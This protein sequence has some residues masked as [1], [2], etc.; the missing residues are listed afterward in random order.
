MILSP[1]DICRNKLSRKSRAK[2]MARAQAKKK[3]QKQKPASKKSQ[4][5][6]EAP[7]TARRGGLPISTAA[8]LDQLAQVNPNAAGIDLGATVHFVAVP[9]GR[10][11]EAHVRCFETFTADLQALADWLEQCG[12][13]TVAMESTGIY[14]I[15]L[16]DLLE[17]R[18]FEVLLINPSDF[19][20]FRRK[21]DVSDCQW[22]QTLHTFGLLQ[23]SFRPHEKI[24]TLRSY[25]RH[26]DNLV[27]CATDEVR[28]MQKALE[29]MNVKLTEVLSDIMGVTGLAIIRAILAGER[30]PQR[31]AQLRD[32]RCKNDVATIALA[33]EGNWREEHLFALRQGL[34]LYE[35]YLQKLA[36]LDEQIEACL[37][38]FEDRSDG[39][40]LS[41]LPRNRALEPELN[42]R[43]LM[44]KL[45]GVDL[46][47]VDGIG[48]QGALQIISEI[49]L[50][51]S[52][53]QTDKH[54]VS[55]LCLCP[56]LRLT[57]GSRKS[58]R[59]RTQPSKNRAAAVFRMGAQSLLRVDCALGAFGR[60]IRA[61]KG[62]AQAVTA[63]ARKLA[64]IVYHMLKEGRPYKDQGAAYYEARYRDR[65]VEGLRRR[66]KQLGLDVVSVDTAS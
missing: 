59:S 24:V 51:M 55:W 21:T 16:Y 36:Y 3:K 66:A 26:R 9:P 52:R 65:L 23:G 54:F 50:D 49:G 2:A 53:W 34:E 30:D 39:E 4:K 47:A 5:Q 44:N 56:E 57:G 28:R 46:T 45:T 19:K 32:Q 11:P 14:W 22:L 63:V 29:Q 64:I 15:P 12:I 60:R 40:E 62:G 8:G 25:L 20:K 61:K 43:D 6:A 42:L 38:T 1:E 41:P 17:E 35:V 58:K 33:L 48:G 27:K 10:D 31:L 37:G 13:T 18:G 7:K